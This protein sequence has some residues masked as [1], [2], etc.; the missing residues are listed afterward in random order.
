MKTTTRL[1]L[2][3]VGFGAWLC[4]AACGSN[5]TPNGTTSTGG[6]VAPVA[7][8]GTVAPVATG[9][10]VEPISTGGIAISTG[11]IAIS[12]GGIAVPIATGGIAISTGGTAGTVATGGVGG[13]VATGGSGGTTVASDVSCV[14]TVQGMLVCTGFSGLSAAAV[15]Q[16][17]T[18]CTQG[19]QGTFAETACPTANAFGSCKYTSSGTGQ[20]AGI[21]AGTVVVYVYY[22]PLTAQDM[23]TAP[24]VCTTMLGGTWTAG[25]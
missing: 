4:F 17:Q 16:E 25:S 20:F 19:N 14:A 15:T 7:T 6:T 1:L 13:T 21:P 9:G 2:A 10:T 12:T 8:G 11:G 5:S 18:A 22:L 24:T 3:T 23:A